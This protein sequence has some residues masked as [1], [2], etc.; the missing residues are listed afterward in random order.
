MTPSKNKAPFL[1]L[2]VRVRQQP[3]LGQILIVGII[4]FLRLVG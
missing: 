1:G 2:S 4:I 3:G